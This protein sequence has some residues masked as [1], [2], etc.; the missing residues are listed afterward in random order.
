[1]LFSSMFFLWGF[2][3]TVLAADLLISVLPF[4][5]SVTR[6]RVKNRFLLVASLLFYAWGGINCLFIMLASILL[7]YTGGLILNRSETERRKTLVLSAVVFLNLALLFYFKYFNLLIVILESFGELRHGFHAFL[8]SMIGM[9]GT[10]VLGIRRV[11]LPIG[12]SFFTFQSMSYVIDLK[13]GR[14]GVQRNLLDFALYVSFFPQLIAGPIVRYTEI[15]QQLLGRR[16]S[17]SLFSEGIRRF[18]YGLG[19]K[20]LLANPL[21]LFVDRIFDGEIAGIGA[22]AAWCAIVAYALQIYFD[23]SGYSDMAIGIGR[24]L[25]F[26]F[27]ENFNAP[28]LATSVQDFWRRWHISLSTWFREYVYFPL[29]GSRKG[30]ARTCLNVLI[31]FCLTGIWHGANFTF[32]IWGLMYAVLLILERLFL[33]N[34]LKRN[35]IKPLNTLYTLFFVLIGWVFFRADTVFDAWTFLCEMFSFRMNGYFFVSL[36]SGEFLL[37]LCVGLFSIGWLSRCLARPLTRINAHPVGKICGTVLQ[38]S[39][40]CLSVGALVNGTYNPFIY[41]RF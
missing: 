4:R 31:V 15:E 17:A 29:G 16:E 22:P 23:F 30:V 39:I 25:G 10:G 18:C 14:I 20:V 24:M 40:L 7:N 36:L 34:W 13:R 27:G 41:F 35:P 6:N 8:S 1:M 19:K 2:L 37:A 38:L 5:S 3:P 12:I 32:L 11:V 21:A 26:S 33:G 9:T 28:Y